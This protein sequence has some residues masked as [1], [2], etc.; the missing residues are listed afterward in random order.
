M[1]KHTRKPLCPVSKKFYSTIT[2]RVRE[3]LRLVGREDAAEETMGCIDRYMADGSLPPN[4]SDTTVILVF[5]LLRMEIDKALQ[6]SRR[7]ANRL[8]RRLARQ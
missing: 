4:G 3:S 5:N 7:A 1:K 8:T 2:S 6:R